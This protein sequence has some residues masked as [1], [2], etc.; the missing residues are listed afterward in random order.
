MILNFALRA[1]RHLGPLAVI[2]ALVGCVTPAPAPAPPSG[3]AMAATADPRA[4]DAALEIM[5]R[6]GNA[7]D[8]AIAAEFVLGLVEPQ[9]SGIGGGAFLLFYDATSEAITGFDGRERAPAGA[10]PGMFLDAAGE[11]PD[12]FDA[13]VSGL[14][15]GTPLLVA[16]LKH[17]HDKHGL[18]PWADLATPAIRIAE[19]GFALS[20][21]VA[22]ALKRGPDEMRLREDPAARAYLFDAQGN[23]WPAGHIVRNP[24]Y[25]ATLR[26]IAAQG[27][28]A[29]SEGPIAQS[30]VDAAQRGPRPG[31]LSL[32]DLRD[33]QPKTFEPLCAPHRAWRV[34]TAAPPSSANAMLAI[35]GLY[36]RARPLPAG[37]ANP[38]DWAAYLWASRIAYVDRDHYMGDTE[39]IPAPTHEMISPAYLDAR[40]R[41]IDLARAPAK[42]LPGAPAGEAMRARWGS[43]DSEDAGTTHLS[44]VDGWGNAVSMTATVESAF[45]SQRMASGFFLNN[46]LTDF[47][48]RPTVGGKPVANAVAPRKRPR[49]SMSPTIVTDADG[50][51]V[52]V[53]GSP[54]GSDII[55][56]VARATIGILDWNLPLQTALDLGNATARF[57]A[58]EA[59]PARW[60]AGIGE[61]L[62]ARGWKLVPVNLWSGLQAIHV[63][64]KGLEGAADSRGEGTVGRL[65]PP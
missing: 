51:L 33:A 47:S 55:G 43:A 4:T 18:L 57:E 40:A 28:R 44:I 60:P 56:Y 61:T 58:V 42:M 11:P 27:P 62:T 38:D 39:F 14:S 7:V 46:E 25:A 24:A 45:G 20:P 23:P 5:R 21:M 35:L 15:I 22:D 31:T 9:S 1:A 13:Q 26:A 16:M 59:E 50:E 36:E 32:A 52:L 30:I 49:S 12:F 10:T 6:G 34:C 65:P 63:T 53:V 37:A 19:D 17:A 54:G 29:L 64:P 41:E 8:A 3:E 2:A 48:F